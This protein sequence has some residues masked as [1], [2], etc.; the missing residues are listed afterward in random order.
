MADTSK[1]DSLLIRINRMIDDQHIQI[2]D[3]QVPD[4]IELEGYMRQF[5]DELLKLSG[6]QA[7]KYSE[8]LKIWIDSIRQMTS[9]LERYKNEVEDKLNDYQNHSGAINAYKNLEE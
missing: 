9:A 5:D 1:I 7:R 2:N 4:F 8:I 3:N 6:E